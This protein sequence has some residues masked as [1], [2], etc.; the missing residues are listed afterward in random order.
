MH[1]TR[2][3]KLILKSGINKPI[4]FEICNAPLVKNTKKAC[5][6]RKVLLE[7]DTEFSHV[8]DELAEVLDQM[9]S[10]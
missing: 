8:Y 3:Y 6:N 10:L 2:R 4:F 5:D 7:I 9:A 1:M